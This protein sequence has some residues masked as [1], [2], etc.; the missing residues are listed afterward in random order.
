[1][2]ELLELYGPDSWYVKH[3]ENNGLIYGIIK[4]GITEFHIYDEKICGICY[5]SDHRYFYDEY[6]GIT[7]PWII[8]QRELSAVERKLTELNI[9]FT[10]HVVQGPL[11]TYKTAGTLWSYLDE[12]EHVFIDTEG[13]VTFSF[14]DKGKRLLNDHT[15]KD[16][17]IIEPDKT[18]K[19]I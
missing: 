19:D 18:K 2:N 14:Y 4:M 5:R 7:H 12:T 17:N 6:E 3:T 9:G 16:Y 15:R 13:G 8:R 11:K 1:M 10:K